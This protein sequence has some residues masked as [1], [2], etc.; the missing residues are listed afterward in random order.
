MVEKDYESIPR[1]KEEGNSTDPGENV[2]HSVVGGTQFIFVNYS[3][4]TGW[5]LNDRHHFL[6]SE[7]RRRSRGAERPQGVRPRRRSTS[8][9][10]SAGGIHE[11]NI[12]STMSTLVQAPLLG[13]IVIALYI[14][15]KASDIN[16]S[17]TLQEVIQDVNCLV[18]PA[19]IRAR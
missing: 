11:Y 2:Q 6:D 18:Q 14:L 8:C 7:R 5:H 4:Y 17:A 16:Q 9:H 19:S 15:A 12:W 3:Y 10:A 1:Q 13:F